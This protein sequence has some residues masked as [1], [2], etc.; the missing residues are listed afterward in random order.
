MERGDGLREE[1]LVEID[2]G[3]STS[4]RNLK[5]VQKLAA[6]RPVYEVYDEDTGELLAIARQTWTSFFRSTINMDDPYGPRILT[7]KGGFFDKTFLIYD[8]SGYMVAK[9]TRPWIAFMKRFTIEYKD[10]IIY[11]QGGVMAWGFEAYDSAGQ[12]AFILDKTVFAIR[13]QF[14]VTVGEYMDWQ[15]AVASAIVVDKMFH[16]G[17]GGVFAFACFALAMVFF[18]Y[19]VLMMMS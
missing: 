4:R 16:E 5:V 2:N 3:E 7:I 19:F 13:D 10:D 1:I 12:F 11:A 9:I 14:R 15:H 6:L 8:D 18:L 17:E